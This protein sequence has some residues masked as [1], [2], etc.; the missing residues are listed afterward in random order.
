[1]FGREDT[2]GDDIADA[3]GNCV[4]IAN[5]DQRATDGDGFGNIC[6]A[7]LNGDCFVNFLDLGGMK[8]VFFTSDRDADLNGDHRVNFQDL[9]LLRTM[10]FKPPGPSG[11]PN[12]CDP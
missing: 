7:D 11:I 2:D 1:V 3:A 8:A 12:V 9:G 6:D 5:A 4:L 10:F